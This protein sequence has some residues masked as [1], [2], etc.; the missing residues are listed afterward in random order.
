MAFGE[1]ATLAEDLTQS[2][3]ASTAF[4]QKLRLTTPAVDVGKYRIGFSWTWNNENTF[5]DTAVQIELDDTTQLYLMLAEPSDASLDQQ[6]SAGGFAQ[7]DLTAGVHTFDMD[8]RTSDAVS[9]ARIAQARL[10]FWKVT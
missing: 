8:F 3:T 4:V 10:E 6:R 9:D 2:T 7:V 1:F 5:D